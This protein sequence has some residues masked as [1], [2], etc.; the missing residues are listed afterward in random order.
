MSSSSKRD[1]YV[2]LELERT[3]D[4]EAIKKAYRRLVCVHKICGRG[5]LEGFGGS[6]IVRACLYAPLVS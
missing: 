4:A 2:V 3:A 1:Y 5:R 6:L